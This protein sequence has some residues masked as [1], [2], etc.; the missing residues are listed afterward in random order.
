MLILNEA[1]QPI[2]RLAPFLFW[3]A[4]RVRGTTITRFCGRLMAY[5]PQHERAYYAWLLSVAYRPGRRLSARQVSPPHVRISLWGRY[6]FG[7]VLGGWLLGIEL[8]EPL[9]WVRRTEETL[10]TATP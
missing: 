3:R 1:Y 4:E 2:R 8:G 10:V 9:V 5:V 7:M 6:E